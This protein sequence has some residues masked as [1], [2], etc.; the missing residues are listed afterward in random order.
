MAKRPKK[1]IGDHSAKTGGTIRAK[2]ANGT[3][4]PK[5]PTPPK[6]VPNNIPVND[7]TIWGTMAVKPN[8][9]VIDELTFAL[10]PYQLTLSEADDMIIGAL[11][12][13]D[14]ETMETTQI[15]GVDGHTID[16]NLVIRGGKN[17][18]IRLKPLTKI[19]VDYVNG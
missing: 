15:N 8:D 13:D 17:N 9:P 4:S 10:K 6:Q 7:P 1:K 11:G 19:L 12:L 16:N 2:R 3:G 5:I 14:G 18:T